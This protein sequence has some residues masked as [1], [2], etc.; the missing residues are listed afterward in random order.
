MC[1]LPFAEAELLVPIKPL[2]VSRYKVSELYPK[3]LPND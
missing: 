1:A 3:V 2:D